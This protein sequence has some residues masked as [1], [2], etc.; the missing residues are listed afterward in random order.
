MARGVF[1]RYSSCVI[2]HTMGFRYG[3]RV[4]QD[5]R[6]RCGGRHDRLMLRVAGLHQGV[7]E[8]VLG[9]LLTD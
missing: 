4:I 3:N 5:Y 6:D 8:D 9:Q 2:Q 7:S 1:F